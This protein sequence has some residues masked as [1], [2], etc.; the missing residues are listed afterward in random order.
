MWLF[1]VRRKRDTTARVTK[2]IF[3]EFI[4]VY[5]FWEGLLV[6]KLKL[7]L[8]GEGRE[9]KKEERNNCLVIRLILT[10]SQFAIGYCTRN[11]DEQYRG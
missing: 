10:D 3:L 6:L 4:E 7:I 1:I 9:N 5:N 8:I 11:D 2:R